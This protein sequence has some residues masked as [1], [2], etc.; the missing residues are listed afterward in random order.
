M[1]LSGPRLSPSCLY[2]RVKVHTDPH[3]GTSL[4]SRSQYWPLIGPCSLTLHYPRS[5]VIISF[6]Q[7]RLC[8][9]WSPL[10]T[11][12]PPSLSMSSL[13]GQ[14]PA[15]VRVLASSVAIADKAGDIVR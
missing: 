13:S 4:V 11:Q 15:L 12:K 8:L 10:I 2:T 9:R 14:P 7:P 5:R 1:L 6:Y 3:A